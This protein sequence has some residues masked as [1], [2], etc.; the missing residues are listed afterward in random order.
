MK[1]YEHI[2]EEWKNRNLKTTADLEQA[3]E[4]Y[5]IL[6][7]FHSNKIE[8]PATT[9]HDTREIFEHG[10]VSDYTGVC[11]ISFPEA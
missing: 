5:R 1:N 10:R 7:A 8:N 3:L 4:N 9:Y 11:R 6:F 2:A